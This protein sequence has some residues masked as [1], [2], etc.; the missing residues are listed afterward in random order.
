MKRVPAL[1]LL[2]FLSI[3]QICFGIQSPD[4]FL[5]FPLGADRK[6]AD[7]HQIVQYFK[8]LEKSSPKIKIENLGNTTDNND[9]IQAIISSEENISQLVKYR[10]I[11]QKLAHP[12]KINS[13]E[14][15]QLIQQGK[16]VAFIT[17]NIHS[18]EIGASQMVMEF[19]YQLITRTDPQVQFYLDN[20]IL[21]LM[22]SANPDGQIMV[23]D[24]YRQ[25]VGT[26]YEGGRM[27][28]LYHRYVGHDTNRDFFMLNQRNQ[29]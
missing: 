17:C 29:N 24:W 5:G 26:E 15:E 10:N 12:A 22:P 25:W 23:T 3:T 4:D 27:P 28:W 2:L 18:T 8:Y 1:I 13:S 19:A 7:Y 21:I 20:V 16:V 11:S 6:L 14:A 9:L